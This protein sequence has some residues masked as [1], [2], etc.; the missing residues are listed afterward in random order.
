MPF[1]YIMYGGFA[2]A[3]RPDCPGGRH[4][5]AQ[6]MRT[7]VIAVAAFGILLLAVAVER[8]RSQ[9]VLHDRASMAAPGA[10]SILSPHPAW[11]ALLVLIVGVLAIAAAVLLLRRVRTRMQVA[12][13]SRHK[14]RRE[15]S[16]RELIALNAKLEHAA[17]EW[18]ATADTIDAGLIV[19]EPDGVIQR[20][21]FA[22][23]DTLPDALPL[24]LGRPSS[25][26]AAY[27]PWNAALALVEDAVNQQGVVTDRVRDARNRT[28]DLWCRPMPAPR[29]RAGR[30]ERS[31]L[32]ALPDGSFGRLTT[33][34][35]AFDIQSATKSCPAGSAWLTGVRMRSV[36]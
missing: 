20:M 31:Q 1:R 7:Q 33:A 10:L 35:S 19:L 17:G 18:R 15:Q 3:T 22:A 28:W 2:A 9:T 8:S 6:K 25:W 5:R 4:L 30:L 11:V 12:A 24:W 34:C 26:L 32:S 16:Y 27:S 21:N 13:D 23:A 14:E 29:C 36:V